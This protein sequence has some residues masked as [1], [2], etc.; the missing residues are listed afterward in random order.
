MLKTSTTLLLAFIINFCNTSLAYSANELDKQPIVDEIEITGLWRTKSSVVRRELLF[1]ENDILTTKDLLESVQRLKNLRIF[2]KVIPLLKLKPENKVKLTLQLQEK[3]TTIPYFNLSG[4]GGTTYAYAGI[5]DINTFGRF[6]ETGI[7]YNNWNGKHGGIAWMRNPRFL[8]QRL[9]FGMDIWRTQRV[10]QLYANNAELQGNY[11]LET[12]KLN[13]ILKK[14]FTPNFQIGSEIE[15]NN[16]SVI[17][18]ETNNFTDAKTIQLL[19]NNNKK[20][21]TYTTLFVELGK[22]NYD[23]YLVKGKFSKF[24]IKYSNQTLGS[25]KSTTQLDWFNRI[26]WRLPYLANAGLRFN[27]GWTN[28]QEIQNLYYI[29]GFNNIRGYLDGQ[30]RSKTYWQFNAEYRI[31]SYRSHWLVLQHIFFIDTVGTGNNFG[32]LKENGMQYSSAGIGLRIISPRIYRFNGRIDIALFTS[33]ESPSYIS[34][35]SQQYF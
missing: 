12:K 25:D 17:D 24:A 21:T 6:I 14:E 34:F 7:Q 10:R 30:F 32:D 4:G 29:G 9:L 11:V 8:D 35:G 16:S 31:P 3:W 2:S 20:T 13:L 5:Y 1:R 27:T 19:N 33:G 23:N 18:Q 28:T 22:L 26:F 15:I